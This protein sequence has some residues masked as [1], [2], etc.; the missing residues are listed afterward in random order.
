MLFM[1]DFEQVNVCWYSIIMWGSYVAL[2][3]N[4]EHIQHDI[5]HIFNKFAKYLLTENLPS[6]SA[7]L[8]TL[9]KI[10]DG[11]FFWKYL[12]ALSK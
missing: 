7:V 3:A 4:F 8:T 9:S 5:Q 12:T 6:P 10:Y 11:A 1:V 2:N